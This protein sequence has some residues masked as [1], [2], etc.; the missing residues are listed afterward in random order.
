M[1][2]RKNDT[3]YDN[4][5]N[6]GGSEEMAAENS[7]RL[8]NSSRLKARLLMILV[9][10]VILFGACFYVYTRLRRFR[11]YKVVHSSDVVFD[12]NSKFIR[13]GDNILKYS[14]DGVSYIDSNGNNV[15]TAGI[16]TTNPAIWL[17][18][19][20]F[21]SAMVLPSGICSGVISTG[22]AIAG[23]A[24]LIASSLGFIILAGKLYKMMALYK[25]NKV[26]IGKAI[27]MLAGK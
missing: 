27:K 24:I 19:F 5:I 14:Q 6:I 23:L 15:W 17:Y 8:R 22:V 11:G 1:A 16:N 2:F 13:F 3:G 26:N 4:V 10:A 20:P 18:L 21:T 25:G 7:K 9:T 12:T